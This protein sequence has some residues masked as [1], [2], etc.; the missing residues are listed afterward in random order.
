MKNNRIIAIHLLN[1][2]SGSPFVLRQSLEVLVKEGYPTELYT[3]TPGKRGFLTDIKGVKENRLFYRRSKNKWLTLFFFLHS[4]G[5]LF[6]KLLLRVKKTDIMYINSMLPFG[7][8]L[9]GKIR[10]CKIVYHI[11]EVS[12]KPVQLRRFLVAVANWSSNAGLFVSK[13]VLQRT[14]FQKKATVVYNTL[15]EDFI[16]EAIQ[17]TVCKQGPFSILMLCSLKKYKGVM[18]F[19]ACARRLPRFTFKLVLN[20]TQYEIEKF[21]GTEKLPANLEL[22]PAQQN[23]HPFYQMSDVVMNLSL[24]DE[25]IETFGMTILEAMYYKKPVIVPYTGGITELVTDGVEGYRVNPGDINKVCDLLQ[26]MATCPSLYQSLSVNSFKK[27]QRFAPGIFT[28]GLVKMAASL[29]EARNEQNGAI[30]FQLP[31][32]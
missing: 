11:H 1:D 8:A 2:F 14:S 19:L 18:Q 7:A 27:A 23:V 30:S 25:W 5:S 22:Y 24:P 3:A 21:F 9:A 13:D 12:I 4:Q 6:F 28:A 29:I 16:K 15:P 32:F 10:G 31:L 17:N 20:A 26:L